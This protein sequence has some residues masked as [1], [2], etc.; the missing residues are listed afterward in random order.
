MEM[1]NP[2]LILVGGIGEKSLAVLV[3]ALVTEYIVPTE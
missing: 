3:G 1:N 2:E